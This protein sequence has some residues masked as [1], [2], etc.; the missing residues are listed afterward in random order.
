MLYHLKPEDVTEGFQILAM[1][2]VQTF[3]RLFFIFLNFTLQ[4]SN[5]RINLKSRAVLSHL[6]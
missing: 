1:L 2:M 3:T 4:Q 6:T 5:Y